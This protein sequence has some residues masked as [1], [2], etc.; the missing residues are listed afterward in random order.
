MHPILL[1]RVV[2]QLDA[3]I[4]ENATFSE[5]QLSTLFQHLSEPLSRLSRLS[6]PNAP[7]TTVAPQILAK[8]ILNIRQVV[9]PRA[10]V[11]QDQVVELFN[12]LDKEKRPR[13]QALELRLVDLASIE[14]S[15]FSRV[16]GRLRV[17]ELYDCKL[18]RHQLHCLAGVRIKLNY[19]I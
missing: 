12:H 5:V 1:A 11:F 16:V 14:P 7:L 9:L 3:F 18:S 10:D 8:A 19:Y 6:F 17:A 13:L 2:R 15:L 4:V